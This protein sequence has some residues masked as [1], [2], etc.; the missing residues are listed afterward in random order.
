MNI[1][2]RLANTLNG[3]YPK[4]EAQ[5]IAYAMVEH[6][7]GW[8]RT[9]LMTHPEAEPTETQTT[10]LNVAIERLQRFEPIQYI[11]GTTT[12]CGLTFHTDHRALIPRPETEELVAWCMESPAQRILD[13]GTG[14]GCIAISLA[15]QLPNA[16]V[17]AFD[18]MTDALSLAKENALLN[19]VSVDFVEQDIL[20]PTWTP[21]QPFDLIV[22]NPPYIAESE[23]SEMDHNVLDH[24]PHTAL[25]VPDN[26]PL[27]FYRA[28]ANYAQQH[29]VSG[30]RLLVEINQQLSN[31]TAKLLEA[32]GFQDVT[33]R[34]DIN[35]N[36]RMIRAVKR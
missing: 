15:H 27:V 29:L 31:E 7:T 20:H 35:D 8:D 24:E 25:F 16:E 4:S 26:D 28:I 12:F 22:S 3:F 21:C 10:Q 5:A 14:T 13:I 33:I 34:N 9:Y 30:G 1:A 23:Q 6:L 17:T 18:L 32:H 2:Q 11:I 36:P 19:N